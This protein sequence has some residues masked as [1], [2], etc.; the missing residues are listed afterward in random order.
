MS[1]EP[2]PPPPPPP[3]P[4]A[5]EPELDKIT[6][7]MAEADPRIIEWAKSRGFGGS[8]ADSA[9]RF[10]RREGLEAECLAALAGGAAPSGAPMAEGERAEIAQVLGLMIHTP[11]AAFLSTRGRQ[12]P[13]V[14]A[15]AQVGHALV[16][17][18][19]KRGWLSADIGP[20]AALVVATVAYAAAVGPA[21]PLPAPEAPPDGA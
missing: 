19:E 6:A 12:A 14:E 21:P 5:P 15:A 20:E 1:G 18:A 9:V 2:A 16:R 3:P 7:T 11:T 13:P 8:K 10:L 4:A 17:L